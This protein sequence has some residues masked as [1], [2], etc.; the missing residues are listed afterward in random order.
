MNSVISSARGVQECFGVVR[1][2]GDGSRVQLVAPAKKQDQWGPCSEADWNSRSRGR[3]LSRAPVNTITVADRRPRGIAARS[4]LQE[5]CRGRPSLDSAAVGGCIATIK[6]RKGVRSMQRYG[7]LGIQVSWLLKEWPAT[8]ASGQSE[9]CS[10]NGACKAYPSS[11]ASLQQQM[12]QLFPP[13]WVSRTI[14]SKRPHVCSKLSKRSFVENG[15][16]NFLALETDRDCENSL[17]GPLSSQGFYRK[18]FRTFPIRSAILSRSPDTKP[19]EQHESE[20]DA[21]KSS[22]E[23]TSEEATD[24]VAPS[25]VF[26]GG[27]KSGFVSFYRQI[28]EQQE[29]E[30]SS[31]TRSSWRTLLWLLGPIMLTGSVFLPPLFLRRIFGSVL[32][33]SLITDFVILIFTETLFFIGASVYLY[34]AHQF[35]KSVSTTEQKPTMQLPLGYRVSAIVSLGIGL[36]LPVATYSMV[37]PWTGPAALAALAPITVGL[38]VQLSL[39]EVAKVKRSPV[40][41]LIPITFQIYRLHQLNRAAQLISGLMFS[42]KG[43]EATAETMAISGSLQTLLFVLKFLGVVCFWSLGAFLTHQLPVQRPVSSSTASLP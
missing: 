34:I 41:P 27:G 35:R 10:K 33:D 25:V 12:Q 21:A 5:C 8:S 32:S 9:I 19:D 4:A 30:T 13:A 1:S 43:V 2:F 40:W 17:G 15:G 11:R 23:T 6:S 29:P 14:V 39:E 24:S 31:S 28:R 7:E 38:L 26:E 42:L 36:F 18:N 16:S 3:V 37:W 20:Q 22:V